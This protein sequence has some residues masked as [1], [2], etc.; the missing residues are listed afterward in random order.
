ML[1]AIQKVGTNFALGL[2]TLFTS[3]GSTSTVYVKDLR[4]V[5]TCDGRVFQYPK[6][7][8]RIVENGVVQIAKDSYG[9]P[10]RDNNGEFVYDLLYGKENKKGKGPSFRL[11]PV[12]DINGNEYKSTGNEKRYFTIEFLV[13][14][15]REGYKDISEYSNPF[16]FSSIDLET[17]LPVFEIQETKVQ[18]YAHCKLTEGIGS[19]SRNGKVLYTSYSKPLNISFSEIRDP[20]NNIE[21]DK[22]LFI[23]VPIVFT[24]SLAQICANLVTFPFIKL[25]EYLISKENPVAKA[26]GY[27]L[28]VPSAATKN[29]VNMSA[30]I[31]RAPIL[32]FV[33]NEKKYG[34]AYLTMWKYQF[35]ECWKQTNSDF[36]LIKNGARSEKDNVKGGSERQLMGTWKELNAENSQIKRDLKNTGKENNV[37]NT[38]EE[39]IS[40]YKAENKEKNTH[41][42][43]VEKR[44]KS[45]EENK[46]CSIM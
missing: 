31:L 30:V 7:Y 2:K 17:R 27:C 5:A 28:F 35:Q 23:S 3:S 43:E 29:L 9:E 34:D 6:N 32:L 26:F 14:K 39:S 33:A 8:N 11:V 20:K 37:L 13:S 42:A 46:G 18:S 41:T 19:K 36:E 16:G 44:R 45:K 24:T 1:G 25:G 12:K 40:S 10:I 4:K 22:S 38:S 15:R 21:W